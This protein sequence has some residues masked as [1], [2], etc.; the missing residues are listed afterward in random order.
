EL[1]VENTG[2]ERSVQRALDR[3]E[4]EYGD[5]L[6]GADGPE[7]NGD[8]DGTAG[9]TAAGTTVNTVVLRIGSPNMT[10]NGISA[11]IDSLGSAPSLSGGNSLLPLRGILVALGGD[12]QYDSETGSVRAVLGEN[13]A[14]VVAGNDMAFINGTAVKLPVAPVA[15]GGSMFVPTKLFMD[16]FGAVSAW[17]NETQSI[18]L[19]FEVG[20]VDGQALLPPT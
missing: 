5:I 7:D 20:T 9:S 1:G 15:S 6:D 8:P 4:S 18:T 10:V 17:D 19:T 13:S 3:L 11:G 2:G 12:T 16:A 14:V